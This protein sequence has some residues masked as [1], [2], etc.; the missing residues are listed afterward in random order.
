MTIRIDTCIV[1][2]SRGATGSAWHAA[3]AID[4][5]IFEATSR[6]G[7]PNALAR[8]LVEAGIPDDDVEVHD[9]DRGEPGIGIVSLRYRSMHEMAKWTYEESAGR[10]LRRVRFRE[11]PEDATGVAREAPKQG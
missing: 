4:E 7:A 5:R 10:P 8:V 6:H 11:R 3:C 2:S 9:L 1:P